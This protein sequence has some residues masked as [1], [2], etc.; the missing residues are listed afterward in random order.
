MHRGGFLLH[1][2]FWGINLT[3]LHLA[4]TNPVE[5][6][7][8]QTEQREKQADN[9]RIK[10]SSMNMFRLFTPAT[11]GDDYCNSGVRIQSKCILKE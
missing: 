2:K 10:G 3:R 6:R 9:G 4:D 5:V 7:E 11:I 8:K 1:L